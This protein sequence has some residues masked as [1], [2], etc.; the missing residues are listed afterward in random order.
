M[1]QLDDLNFLAIMR[2]FLKHTKQTV[3]AGRY[4]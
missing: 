4:G 3:M 1:T 2:Q